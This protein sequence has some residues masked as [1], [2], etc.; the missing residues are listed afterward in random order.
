MNAKKQSTANSKDSDSV[1]S[2]SV[3]CSNCLEETLS[4][5]TGNLWTINFVGTTIKEI[6][7]HCIY[8][9]SVVAEKRFILY[10]IPIYSY[11]FFRV[12]KNITSHF[13]ARKLINQKISVNTYKQNKN[14]ISETQ[15]PDWYYKPVQRI[16]K[17]QRALRLLFI[18]I[19][20]LL[21]FI[22]AL[23]ISQFN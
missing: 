18:F 10:G 1:D 6:G 3:F 13:Y 19:G 8:C 17:K 14:Y 22:I 15:K 11:G 20:V 9:D 5:S 21:F 4:E 12:K 16:S 2:R 23:L 7:G